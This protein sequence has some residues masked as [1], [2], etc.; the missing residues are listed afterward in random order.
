MSG[1]YN[2][3]IYQ[4]I[5]QLLVFIYN[6]LAFNDLGLAIIILT[7]VIR[8]VFLPLFHKST[9]G[10]MVLQKLQPEVEKIK[11]HHKNSKEAQAAALME[12]YR[13][14]GVNPFGNFLLL[15]IQLPVLIALYQVF[16]NELSG[17]LFATHDF[18]GLIDLKNRSNLLVGLSVAAQYFQGR[19]LQ[20]PQKSGDGQTAKINQFMVFLGPVITFMILLNLPAAVALYWLVTTI[21]SIG[22]Q[23]YIIKGLT[24][25]SKP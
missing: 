7:V 4:P 3:F 15:I 6:H 16:M 19:Q 5:L 23:F 24:Q 14:H 11:N 12:L 1:I 8:F 18:L 2:Q 21:F 17:T 9:K 10:Q 22:H 13:R 25:E 20:L